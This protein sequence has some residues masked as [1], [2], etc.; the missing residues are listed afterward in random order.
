MKNSTTVIWRKLLCNE[1]WFGNVMKLGFT[2]GQPPSYEGNLT[3]LR[4][5]FE[6]LLPLPYI[7]VLSLKILYNI[8][9]ISY[10]VFNENIM[11]GHKKSQ[12]HAVFYTNQ[13]YIPISK[14]Y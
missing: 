11:C 13:S 9:R 2:N 8:L 4:D 10:F 12:K 1:T 7:L 14:R 5:T 3:F 6:K